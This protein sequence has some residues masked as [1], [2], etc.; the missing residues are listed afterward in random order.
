MIPAPR[1]DTP[2]LEVRE[3][4]RYNL[5]DGTHCPAC[6]QYAKVYRRKLT[7]VAAV[8]MIAMHRDGGDRDGW[9]HLPT[10][11]PTKS[12]GDEAKAQHWG[13]IEP[14]PDVERD[15]GSR[16]TGWWR[17][18]S[19]GARFVSRIDRIP[20]YARIYDGE[21]LNLEGNLIS[22]QDCLGT[23]FNYDDL[24]AGI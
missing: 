15:D 19:H 22:I 20:K 17:L 5:E 12:G 13:L 1:N 3:W 8:G 7:A 18:T 2:L 11:L 14:M 6:T 21:C 23:R 10:L 9:I 24:M 16:H 4:L